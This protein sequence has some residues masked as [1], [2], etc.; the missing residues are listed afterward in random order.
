MESPRNFANFS[1]GM[2]H[3][4]RVHITAEII[5]TYGDI[6]GDHNPLH[7]DAEFAA[8]RFGGI[9][10][11][12]TLLIGLFSAAT[13]RWLGAGAVARK[14]DCKFRAP[15]RAGDDVQIQLK[16]IELVP[17]TRKIVIEGRAYVGTTVLVTTIIEALIE[18]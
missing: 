6:I 16:I 2:S 4:H 7:T 8:P 9:I 12:G 10:G 18:C 1:V 3:T 5:A 17:K 11:H 15:F 14:F 13:W